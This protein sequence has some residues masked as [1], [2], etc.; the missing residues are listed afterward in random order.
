MEFELAAIIS[1]IA[2]EVRK[3]NNS[4][5]E[6]KDWISKEKAKI[7]DPKARSYALIAE[8]F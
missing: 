3:E 2:E 5:V 1:Q 8:W 4:M 7:D 6:F